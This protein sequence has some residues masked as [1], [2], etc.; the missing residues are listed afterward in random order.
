MKASNALNRPVAGLVAAA[1][2]VGCGWLW[3]LCRHD[4]SIP[5]LPDGGPAEWIVY[6]KP[7]DAI[8]HS[9]MPFWA[10]FRRSFTLTAA[11]ATAK[12]SVRVF[13]QGMVR[14][15]G[16]PVDSLPL[17]EQDWKSRR[18]REVAKFLQAGENEISVTVSNSL[19]PP[20]LW[21]SLDG[22]ALALHSDPDWQVS[23]VGAAEQK[24]VLASEP[25]AIRPGNHFFG[26]E[27]MINSLRRTWPDL[28]LILLISAIVIGGGNRFLRSKSATHPN[29]ASGAP[30]VDRLAVAPL[31]VLSGDH[32]FV[33]CP[34]WQQLAA[35]RGAV[36]LRSGRSPG[37][38]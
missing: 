15:N 16:R 8:P 7:P 18:T 35:N 17:R 6:P 37:I 32:P 14:I 38:H 22:D 36:R 31:A 2:L 30:A 23:L 34:V 29:G 24:A 21:L 25:P 10:V 26:R 20:A 19:G 4:S 9:A 27:L 28:L 13:K 3:W 5:F 1:I 12:L 11:P 33:D